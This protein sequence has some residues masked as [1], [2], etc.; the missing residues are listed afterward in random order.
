DGLAAT[1]Q[2]PHDRRDLVDGLDL[3]ADG[4]G[5]GRAR[6]QQGNIHG[7]APTALAAPR[8]ANQSR[9]ATEMASGVH[10]G[11]L[12][13]S[14][15]RPAMIRTPASKLMRGRQPSRAAILETSA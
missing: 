5:G 15:S 12:P 9:V 14:A 1:A 6:P 7:A 2:L 10:T 3:V 11:A 8:C 13:N 4:R